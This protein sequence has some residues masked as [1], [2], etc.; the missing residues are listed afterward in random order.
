MNTIHRSLT[1]LLAVLVTCTQVKASELSARVL[2]E[3]F[4]EL[5]IESPVEFFALDQQLPAL[6]GQQSGSLPLR[7]ALARLSASSPYLGETLNNAN[8]G[9]VVGGEHAAQGE[10]PWQV[11]LVVAGYPAPAGQF[12]GGSIVSGGWVLTAAHC[13]DNTA[14]SAFTIVAGDVDLARVSQQLSVSK[15]HTHPDW[16]AL[17]MENDI[18][19][20]ELDSSIQMSANAAAIDLDSRATHA[21]GTLLL[22]SGWGLTEEGGTPSRLLKKVIVPV[23]PLAE[24]NSAV[25]YN[26]TVSTSMI[27]AGIGGKD[28]CQGDSGGPLVAAASAT[29]TQVGVVSWGHGCARPNKPGVYTSV[30]NFHDWIQSTLGE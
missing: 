6:E 22:A 12:C 25:G 9:R 15:I 29:T 26:G 20:L 23:V 10:I 27:C 1:A 28:T 14:P 8:R 17:T 24:C 11:A 7:L 13:V 18:A 2:E 21:G 3:R 16:N 4:D 5:R 30:S 19:L